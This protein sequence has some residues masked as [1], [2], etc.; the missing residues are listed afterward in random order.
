MGTYAL[1]RVIQM[2]PLLFVISL[3]I[4]MLTALQPGD[5]VDQL[6]FGNSNITADDIAR[7]KAAYGLDQ[8]WFTRY[9]FWL[10]QAVVGNFGYSQDFGI[11]ALDFVFRDRLPNTLLL[12]VPALVISTLIAV[13]LGIFSAVRQYSLPDYVLTF[14]AFLAVSAPVF[15]VGALALYFFAVFLPGAT[16]GV[17][18]LP[19]GGLGSADLAPDAGWWATTLDKLKYL[20]LPMMI[21]MLREI[22][23]TL[24]FMR[25]NMLETLTQDYVRTARAKGLGDRRVLYKHALRNAVTPIVTLLGLSIPGLFGGAVITE[26]VFSWP[27]MGKAILDALVS[28]DF[29]VV[30]TCL[31]LLALL[32]VIF[33]LLTDLAYG[34]VDPRVRYS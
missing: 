26:T 24:R 21:L 2:I 18:S 7:L 13:P 8:P 31:M 3:L 27:G 4:F 33:Q 12:T 14:F 23:V 30:M 20:I 19:P 6:V 34:L 32:T 15:W 11:P 22:A 1:R 17:L 5:P 28:K 16:G 10:K 9:F 29:N 25:A